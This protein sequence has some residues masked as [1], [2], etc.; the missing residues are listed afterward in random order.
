MAATGT[1]T[2]AK[3]CL[4]FPKENRDDSF[5]SFKH[6]VHAKVHARQYDLDTLVVGYPNEFFHGSQ[7]VRIDPAHEGKIQNRFAAHAV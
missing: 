3:G 1:E 2:L 5:V 6:F 7:R 4:Q